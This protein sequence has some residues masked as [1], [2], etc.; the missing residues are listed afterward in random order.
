[1]RCDPPPPIDQRTD[2]G[3]QLNWRNLKRLA[4]SNCCQLHI[5]HIFHFMH[6]R[7]S[8]SR[9]IYTCLLQKSKL[10]E[11]MII[12][13]HPK[14]Q[15]HF[16]KN[17]IAGILGTFHK[18]L[19]TVSCSPCTVN[20]PVIHQLIP[21][22]EKS[23]IYGNHASLQTCRHGNDLKGRTGLICIV[24]AGISPHLVQKILFFLFIQS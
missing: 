2:C 3:R 6:D 13:F 12:V 17:R 9:Q 8:L 21:R 14:S 11:I 4:K 7:S 18:A 5:P 16:N 20:P 24:Q 22:T 19:G 23:V 1:M 10:L 15:T